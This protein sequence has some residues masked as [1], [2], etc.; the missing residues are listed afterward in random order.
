MAITSL[1]SKDR[2]EKWRPVYDAAH[3]ADTGLSFEVFLTAPW[4]HLVEQGQETAPRALHN[5]YR[6]LLPRQA[7]IAKRIRSLDVA[8]EQA[9]T[10][11]VS[12]QFR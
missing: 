1:A 10:K 7:K 12:V 2:I 6:P 3:L 11:V 8:R 9:N 4:A 5:G